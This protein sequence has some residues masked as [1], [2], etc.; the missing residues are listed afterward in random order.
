MALDYKGVGQIF[1]GRS[2]GEVVGL[3]EG[4]YGCM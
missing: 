2:V 3:G 4:V 1:G